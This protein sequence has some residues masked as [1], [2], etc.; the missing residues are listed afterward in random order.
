MKSQT[1]FILWAI[2][3]VLGIAACIVKFG[4]DDDDQT[5]TKRA[6]GDRLIAHL[7]IR[8]LTKVSL[9]QGAENT[10]LVRLDED[11]WGVSERDNNPVDHELL[12]NL[13][14][15]LGELNV[16]QAYPS[17]DKHHDRFGLAPGSGITDEAADQALVVTIFRGENA[18]L[19]TVY[20]GK[21]LGTSRS[22][23]RF[24][25]IGSDSGAVY[26]VN[27]TFPGVS[28]LPRDW[29]NKDFLKIDQIETI[30][31]SAPSDPEFTSWK[32]SRQ[33]K[34]DGSVNPDGQFKLADLTQNEVMQ[35][36]STNSFRN[37]F[38]Y[39]N[40]QD[41]LSKEEAAARA[42]PDIKLKRRATITTY[43]GFHY[44]LYLQPLS[45]AVMP[46]GP[47]DRLPPT[48][49]SY[50][51]SIS[52]SCDSLEDATN[53][54]SGSSNGELPPGSSALRKK[55]DQAKSLTGRIFQVSHS[56]I[57]PFLMNRSDFAK[58]SST[59][60]GQPKGE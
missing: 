20:I 39:S 52:V 7:P 4:G 18:I 26:T 50:L 6:P 60:S 13:L 54:D 10:T 8:E 46:A 32:L 31:V 45:Q 15:A 2:A 49:A 27:E 1:V 33:S 51:V 30:E 37:L 48:P 25:R 29:I 19:E 56:T 55:L 41:V 16:T 58:T 40:V 17:S 5:R 22:G 12:R 24:I 28:A 14:G 23:G 35:L 43:D 47:D 53:E 11:R 34:A 44:V 36:T 59:M 57:S 42:N 21:L 38:A 9:G 3:V